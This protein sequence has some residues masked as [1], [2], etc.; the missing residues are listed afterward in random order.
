MN[1]QH[2][3]YVIAL[4]AKII[5]NGLKEGNDYFLHEIFDEIQSQ[6]SEAKKQLPEFHQSDPNVRYIKFMKNKSTNTIRHEFQGD[7]T[8][9][10]SSGDENELEDVKEEEDDSVVMDNEKEGY[11]YVEYAGNTVYKRLN[12]QVELQKTVQK[13]DDQYEQDEVKQEKEENEQVVEDPGNNLSPQ[14][15]IDELEPLKENVESQ[16]TIQQS[17]E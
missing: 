6:L 7:E 4:F 14:L 13:S 12:G 9:I 3:S 2:G 15:G 11:Q 16:N 17:G 1:T 10:M 5:T 8:D